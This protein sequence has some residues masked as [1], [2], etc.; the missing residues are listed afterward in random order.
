MNACNKDSAEDAVSPQSKPADQFSADL[1]LRWSAMQL[2]LTR[3]T[4]GFSPPVASRAF[5]YGGLALY[6]AVVPGLSTHQSLAGQLTNL[7]SLPKIDETAI[8]HWP[9][10]A[11]AAQAQIL[12]NLFA[13]TSEDNKVRIDSLEK[14]LV[15]EFA[16]EGVASEVVERSAAYGKQIADA[17]FDWSKTDGGHEGYNRNFPTDYQ[18][19]VFNGS[20]QPTENGRKI[21]MQPYWGKNRTFVAVNALLPIP[22]PLP[23][24]AEVKSPYFLQYQDVYVKNK[25]LTQNE[26]EISIWWADD[27]SETFTPPGHSYNLARI[28]IQTA[29][30]DLGKAA[31][32]LAKTGIAVADAFTICWKTKYM[33]HNERPYTFVRRTMDPY[34]IPFWPAPPFPGYAS[35]H[36]TQSAASATV[37]GSVFGES[38]AFTDD[39]HVSRVRDVKRSVDFKARS[40]TSFWAAAEESAYSRFLG[41]IHTEQDNETGLSMGR[42]IGQ[43]VAALKWKK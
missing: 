39:S 26:K 19:P 40:F 12:R 35:G 25:S 8:Y 36:A 13:N 29:Q 1:A 21:P 17:I 28:A 2:Y 5:G 24:S 22:K 37:L 41:G 11:N 38:F 34:W 30:A 42:S 31:E 14:L 33:F 43:H 6:E 18:V 9:A 27:P 10:S 23:V 4:A 32:A 16:T 20:W 7:S 3:N 15:T